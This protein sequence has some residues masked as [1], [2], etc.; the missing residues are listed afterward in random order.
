[1]QYMSEDTSSCAA[2]SDFSTDSR[3]LEAVERLGFEVPTP[4]QAQA[5]PLLM[6]GRDLMGQ[7][8][9]GTGKTAAFGLPL[10]R[11]VNADSKATQALILAPTR[12]LA[13]QV[14]RA[15][16]EFAAALPGLRV[17]PIYGGQ[18]YGLQ[19]RALRK[20]A[21]IIV[22]TPG[23][24]MDHMRRGSLRLDA[25]KTIVLDEADEMLNMGFVEDIEW[26]LGHCPDE[27]QTTLFS[28][29]MPPRIRSIAAKYMHA[30]EFV[31]IERWTSAAPT[32]RQRY[33]MVR[34][35]HKLDALSRI[36]EAEPLDAALIFVQTKVSTVA[37]AEQLADR[38]F[39]AAALHGDMPQDMRE[40]TVSRL[41][42]GQIDLLVA[43]DVAARGLDIERFSHVINYDMPGD[44][45]AYVHR[46]GRT[47]RAGRDGES[48]SFVALRER[49]L[50]RAIERMTKQTIEPMELPS[51]TQLNSKR[52]QAF[53][54]NIC[55]V[56]AEGELE[57]FLGILHEL[58]AEQS[59]DPFEMAAALAKKAQGNVP[60]LVKDVVIPARKPSR[61]RP[62]RVTA[63][64]G[65]A[66]YRLAVGHVHG[67]NPNHIVGVI[68]NKSGLQSRQIGRIRINQDH[69]LVDLPEGMPSKILHLL[70]K[71][72]VCQVPLELRLVSDQPA[73]ARQKS[74]R[75]P[76]GRA[77]RKAF[78][79]KRRAVSK[80]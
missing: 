55:E 75:R 37:L 22:G 8:Q 12:E 50:L 68:V 40:H 53:K 28:A 24:I 61:P 77:P 63:E 79:H 7:A 46:I 4:I 2:F 58:G 41:K 38:H 42:K 48:I 34:G 5:I 19:L 20:G 67:V 23:R 15:L 16:Q 62:E 25:L 26:I 44:A 70:K 32:I 80:R 18:E 51:A 74:F 29:T 45:E 9:T 76:K 33:W 35:L 78:K 21:H 1:M 47:G 10:L 72:R 56:V 39:K 73:G 66:C 69:S 11:C 52:I 36:L 6:Q 71:I 59:L 13:L 64:P 30:P 27:R 14:A 31:C 57:P 60:L 3:V 43:T 65:M 49:H 54:Q 17:V